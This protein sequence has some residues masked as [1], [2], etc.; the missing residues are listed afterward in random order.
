MG[1]ENNFQTKD[2]PPRPPDC[3]I[4]KIQGW[5]KLGLDMSILLSFKMILLFTKLMHE[6]SE[7][8]LTRTS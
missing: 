8:Q 4:L 7:I 3:S 1:R 2:P 6:N 5:S